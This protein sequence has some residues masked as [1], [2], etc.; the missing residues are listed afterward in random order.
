M[1]VSQHDYFYY[2]YT[3]FGDAGKRVFDTAVFP[4]YNGSIH[5]K[6]DKMIAKQLAHHRI[7]LNESEF[8]YLQ[9]ML[10]FGSSM[11]QALLEIRPELQDEHWEFEDLIITV[12]RTRQLV[13]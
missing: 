11:E 7:I 13:M 2:Y 5:M 3:I 12:H 1:L 9:N 8:E 6:G 4:F 10:D